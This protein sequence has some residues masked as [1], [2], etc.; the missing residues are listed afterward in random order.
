MMSA[1][2]RVAR[3]GKGE[4]R[5]EAAPR[6]PPESCP[7]RRAGEGLLLHPPGNTTTRTTTS[8][9][10]CRRLTCPLQP[11]LL[12]VL[13]HALDSLPLVFPRWSEVRVRLLLC[14]RYFRLSMFH[15]CSSLFHG[16]VGLP[17][18]VPRSSP[19]CLWTPPPSSRF[20]MPSPRGLRHHGEE[21]R[22]RGGDTTAL[23][24]CHQYADDTQLSDRW[25]A[26]LL[27]G[28][29]EAVSGRLTKC[30]LKLNPSKMEVLWLSKNGKDQEVCLP[31]LDGV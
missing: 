7:E 25:R 28:C 11:P 1:A 31:C 27:P 24:T 3:E 26:R 30:H 20:W 18:P 21:G 29:L 10:D 13:L 16:S 19:V 14:A 12:G 17:P 15:F 6:L 23:H 9:P 4:G 8:Q 22:S 2:A 5:V